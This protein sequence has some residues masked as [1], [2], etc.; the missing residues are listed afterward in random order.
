MV[1]DFIIR[2]KQEGS[3][4]KDAA[5]GVEQFGKAA[6]QAGH[7]AGE[8]AHS[9]RETGHEVKELSHL[10]HEA[11]GVMEGLERGGLA[12]L[13]QA[14][15]NAAKV[16]RTLATGALGAVLIP[17]ILAA[18]AAFAVL[19]H[20][21]EAS[22]EA[23]KKIFEEQAARSEKAKTTLEA[24]TKALEAEY[25]KQGKAVAKLA[26][27]YGELY[28]IIDKSA[29]RQK[30]LRDA[31]DEQEDEK[32][33]GQREAQLTKLDTQITAATTP[34]EKAKLQA[35]KDAL[36]KQFKGED[37]VTARDRTQKELA[38]ED[39]T[40]D[41]RITNANIEKGDAQRGIEAARIPLRDAKTNASDA[42]EKVQSARALV[43]KLDKD[44]TATEGDKNKAQASLADAAKEGVTARETVRVAEKEFKEAVEKLTA[45]ITKANETIGDA[46]DAK[47]VNAV[48]AGTAQVKATNAAQDL[49]DKPSDT[50]KA[51]VGD[52]NAARQKQA[53]L[54]GKIDAADTADVA[55]LGGKKTDTSGLQAQLEE[56]RNAE[57]QAYTNIAKDS[58][59]RKKQADKLSQQLK[60]SRETAG[61]P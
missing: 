30:D 36:E 18:T 23:I 51:A 8:A 57:A 40:N 15:T 32:N 59:A 17:V 20:M 3:V 44:P 16:I 49:T 28:Q 41:V 54:K 25:A 61:T 55:T 56:A 33:K 31:K 46:K 21:A 1:L 4:G 26:Q 35:R 19:R 52:L 10:G 50:A 7:K 6:E 14:G 13:A 24:N 38:S 39:A 58:A 53:D 11:Q 29:K 12:G 48:K 37:I 45:V 42:F 47:A 60:N 2:T 34:E 22:A 5:Q 9:F 27:E 43:D